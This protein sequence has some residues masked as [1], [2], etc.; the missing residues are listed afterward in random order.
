MINNLMN[1]SKK[2]LN[3][4]ILRDL[5]E[6]NLGKYQWSAIVSVSLGMF[7]WGFL[8]A[9]APLTTQWP[10]VPQSMVEYVLVSAPVALTIGNLT[11]GR[12]SDAYGRKHIFM[13]TL[14][15]YGIGT[16][17]IVLAENVYTLIMGIVLAEFGL[18]GEEP[19]TLAYLAEMMP[20]KRR[21]SS[22]R[23]QCS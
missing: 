11:I 22:R 1:K 14:V 8:L 19:T 6:S 23:Y 13:L 21:G 7:L 17:L 10:F 18:G 16:L 15:L 9:L 20:I 2:N 3:W 4:G 12:L 5:D